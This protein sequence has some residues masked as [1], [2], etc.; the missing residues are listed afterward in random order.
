MWNRHDR[1]KAVQRIGDGRFL[2]VTR[3]IDAN[4]KDDHP[5]QRHR[6]RNTSTPARELIRKHEVLKEERRLRPAAESNQGNLDGHA[7]LQYRE[8]EKRNH[9]QVVSVGNPGDVPEKCRMKER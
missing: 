1:G 6:T 4:A 7:R 3:H 2:C 9:E 8:Q 5:E